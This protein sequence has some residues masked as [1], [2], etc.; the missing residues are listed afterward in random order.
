MTNKIG[1]CPL[2]P[3]S[4][5]TPR[6]T[7]YKALYCYIEIVI[8]LSDKHIVIK[9]SWNSMLICN[10]PPKTIT[11]DAMSPLLLLISQKVLDQF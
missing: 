8:L 3:R 6:F 5:L 11:A 1:K 9:Q 7:V 4:P 2:V 10:R